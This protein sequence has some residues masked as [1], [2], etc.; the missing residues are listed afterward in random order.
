MQTI[1]RIFLTLTVLGYA[2]VTVKAVFNKT[3]ATNPKWTPHARFHVV[4]Q[5]LSYA[6]R[7]STSYPRL[8][9][10]HARQAFPI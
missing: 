9:G 1:A 7:A 8:G 4:W 2:L 10:C 3:H 5:I 6:R